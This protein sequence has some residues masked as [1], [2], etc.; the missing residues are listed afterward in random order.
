M[1]VVSLFT[2]AGG[3]D[4]GLHQVHS[5]CLF[6]LCCCGHCRAHHSRPCFSCPVFDRSGLINVFSKMRMSG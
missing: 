4:M 5:R 6:L 2:G 1:N 3:L